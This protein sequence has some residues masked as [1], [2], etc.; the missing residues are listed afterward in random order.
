MCNCISIVENNVKERISKELE[1]I[2]SCHISAT[3]FE[4]RKIT[5]DAIV[6]YKQTAKT[7]KIVDKKETIILTSAYCPFCGEKYSEKFNAK[8]I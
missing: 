1:N 7:G 2:Q 5:I 4:P 8:I 3:F 6:R